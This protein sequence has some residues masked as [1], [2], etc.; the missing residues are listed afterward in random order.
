[1]AGANYN[2]KKGQALLVSAF[3]K[4]FDSK[5]R[6]LEDAG[7]QTLGQIFPTVD[8]DNHCFS[9]WILQD[10]MGTSLAAFG[11]T[12]AEKKTQEFTSARHYSIATETVSV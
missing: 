12:I 9:R 10:Q 11:V 7:Q 8:R 4:V 5:A 3:A 6:V 2:S 1:V